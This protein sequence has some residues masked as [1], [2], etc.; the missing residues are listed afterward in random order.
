MDTNAINQLSK[1]CKIYGILN[2]GTTKY[3]LAKYTKGIGKDNKDE[4]K[5][6]ELIKIS[7]GNKEW[8]NEYN[9]DFKITE[10]IRE[11][12]LRPIHFCVCGRKLD[13]LV[14]IKNYS[15]ET[16]TVLLK[17]NKK[18]IVK[19]N[20]ILLI[21][22]A[23]IG[24]FFIRKCNY[25]NCNEEFIKPLS[26]LFNCYCDEH[27]LIKKEEKR[28]KLKEEKRLK[29]IREDQLKEEN[30]LIELRKDKNY[31]DNNSILEQSIIYFD[32]SII[33][34]KKQKDRLFEN[35]ENNINELKIINFGEKYK[36]KNI[37]DIDDIWWK[38]KM[39]E[40]GYISLRNNP[41]LYMKI[42]GHI[43]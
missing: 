9:K 33:K 25:Y 2:Y 35:I 27:K 4:I 15:D 22:S 20:Q 38:N 24:K 32:K 6:K 37:D 3:E 29:K 39:I 1:F 40:K 14:F 19:P 26:N 18:L 10:E 12:I 41:I 34:T 31:F 42:K 30:R 23:C 5:I 21:G 8:F 28:L 7:S 36:N 17:K 13:I 16:H 43:K 11:I